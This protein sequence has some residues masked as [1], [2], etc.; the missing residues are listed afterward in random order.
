MNKLSEI[1]KNFADITSVDMTGRKAYDVC[2]EPFRVYGLLLP[3]DKNDIFRR[4]PSDI[5]KSINPGVE[6][7]HDN[8]AG[9]RVRFATNSKRVAIYVKERDCVAGAKF[10]LSGR[11]GLD[12]Y[13]LTQ[14]GEKYCKH[15]PPSEDGSGIF[16]GEYEFTDNSMRN[17]TLYM[18]SY[19]AVLE[20]YILLDEGCVLKESIKYKYEKPIVYYGSSITQGAN[21]SRPGTAYQNIIARRFDTNYVNLG[22]S[23]NALGERKMA[24][25][26][27][28]LDMSICVLDYDHNAPTVQHLKD[29]HYPMY[30]VIRSAQP[31]LPIVFASKPNYHTATQ[32]CDVANNEQRRQVIIESYNRAKANG[33]ENVY[34]VDGKEVANVFGAGDNMTV[35]G[36]HPNDIGIFS[37]AK[38]IGDTIGE[39]LD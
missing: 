6:K 38:L 16:E 9:G 31:N 19:T 8:T 29:T 34:F 22:F 5:A 30:E 12:L 7:L 21:A 25:Y 4:M 15:F 11:A 18:P 14:N 20:L 3:R 24:E 10:S 1:D 27:A 32:K 39:I 28:G 37:M 17:L 36:C 2:K 13:E 33:D 23:G 35:D 26:I